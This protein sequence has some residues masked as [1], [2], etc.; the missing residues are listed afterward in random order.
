[1]SLVRDIKL[2]SR[3]KSV[4]LT[5]ILSCRATMF[6]CLQYNHLSLRQ[7]P[8]M[9]RHK[10]DLLLL[11]TI[12]ETGD[13]LSKH[14]LGIL[15]I[16]ET[17]QCQPPKWSKGIRNILIQPIYL[18]VEDRVGSVKTD[19]RHQPNENEVTKKAP[20]PPPPLAWHAARRTHKK[21]K[22]RLSVQGL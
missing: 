12:A 22:W 9:W 11:R 14:A 1:M 8:M 16:G 17:Y 21:T 6:K 3:D 13:L 15:A 20:P 5:G 4:D 18:L 10:P 19:T 7:V 2:M